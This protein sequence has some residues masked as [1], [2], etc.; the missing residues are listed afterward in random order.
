MTIIYSNYQGSFAE[1]LAASPTALDSWQVNNYLKSLQGYRNCQDLLADEQSYLSL[2]TGGLF[3]PNMIIRTL[4]DH[5][6]R[7]ASS[8]ATDHHLVTAAGVKIYAEPRHGV[9]TLRQ[10]GGIVDGMTDDTAA[11][12]LALRVVP[13]GGVLDIGGTALI[14]STAST[15]MPKTGVR[16]LNGTLTRSTGGVED[17]NIP[18]LELVGWN[19]AEISLDF[20]LGNHLTLSREV[21][22]S[23]DG[24]Q[25]ISI[26][27]CR[28]DECR[29]GVFASG[30][31]SR[32]IRVTSCRGD[33]PESAHTAT[34]SA[35][36]SSNRGGS[37]LVGGN[38]RLSQVHVDRCEGSGWN[39]LVLSSDASNWTVS[40]CSMTDSGDSAIYLRGSNHRVENCWIHRAGKDGIKLLDFKDGAPGMNNIVSNCCITGAGYTKEDGGICVNSE[41]DNTK[42]SGIIASLSNTAELATTG[43]KGVA[44]S[45]ENV[46]STDIVITGSGTLTQAGEAIGI[47]VNNSFRTTSNITISNARLRDMRHAVSIS[48][49]S[50]LTVNDIFV[51]NVRARNVDVAIQSFDSTG[52]TS[53]ISVLGGGVD[54][55]TGAGIAISYQPGGFILDGFEFRNI[56]PGSPCIDHRN[57][58]VGTYRN[59]FWDGLG[60]GT[61]PVKDSDGG[62]GQQ[63]GNSWQRSAAAT[64][65]Q[66]NHHFLGDQIW[67]IQAAP[68]SAAGKICT[69]PGKV[70][71]S[72]V[73]TDMAAI[74]S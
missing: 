71:V 68:S 3:I 63:V 57:G 58:T 49:R 54:G 8:D 44:V 26:T 11:L 39:H 10:C 1:Y 48:S 62:G 15:P 20:R 28:F 24:C 9:I 67:D 55:T 66:S 32:S 29:I 61:R 38:G 45:G 52:N 60:T 7:I 65:S 64:P 31:P 50:G 13:D 70:G 42:I 16:I 46:T 4:D 17:M 19:N 43:T 51:Q 36:N 59:C 74:A 6:F 27:N 47:L 73:F 22:I 72:A 40:H 23:L 53:N 34:Y 41:T 33:N 14:Q 18:A 69:T 35:S 2:N 12:E 5:L 37:A 30:T 25:D 21:G 56:A